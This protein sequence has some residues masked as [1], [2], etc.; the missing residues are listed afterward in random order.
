M[1]GRQMFQAELI[2]ACRC[3]SLLKKWL[4][5]DL[6]AHSWIVKSP[7]SNMS[8]YPLPEEKWFYGH[9]DKNEII[10]AE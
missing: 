4:C 8:L 10:K 5:K 2:L 1:H 3:I 6:S 7:E 9:V